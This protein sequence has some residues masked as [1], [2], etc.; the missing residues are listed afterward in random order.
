M[1]AQLFLSP[2][3]MLRVGIKTI[4]MHMNLEFNLDGEQNTTKP[5]QKKT[6]QNK[7]FHCVKAKAGDQ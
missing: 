2:K 4:F 7:T 5:R 3:S 6:H 1:R